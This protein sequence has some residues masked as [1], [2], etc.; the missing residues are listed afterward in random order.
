MRTSQ[1]TG[2]KGLRP[3]SEVETDLKRERERA[4]ESFRELEAELDPVERSGAESGFETEREPKRQQA[5]EQPSAETEF[6]PR[7]ETVAPDAEGMAS[8]PKTI[9]D[10]EPVGSRPRFEEATEPELDRRVKPRVQ[11]QPEEIV[12]DT[13]RGA[14]RE[15]TA[16][17]GGAAGEVVSEPRQRRQEAQKPSVEPGP[18]PLDS[19]ETEFDGPAESGRRRVKTEL[20]QPISSRGQP[21]ARERIRQR[22]DER[23][24][25]DDRF[26]TRGDIRSPFE[27]EPFAPE[28]TDIGIRLDQPVEFRKEAEIKTEIG[29]DIESEIETVREVE[30]RQEAR[31]E[32]D[33]G[34]P[35][36]QQDESDDGAFGD[37]FERRT[38]VLPGDPDEVFESIDDGGGATS[39][40]QLDT[41]VE[42]L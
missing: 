6:G 29:S 32:L 2:L 30:S 36:R 27:T 38:E 35:R 9:I 16:G 5:S 25:I 13:K 31:A 1:S 28:P 10:E 39:P 14:D 3:R 40:G 11:P 34:R 42:D 37:L 22:L 7:R 26:D 8:A 4:A 24:D 33:R 12:P 20:G 19:G 21:E 18:E 15:T 17:G 23:L 41:L